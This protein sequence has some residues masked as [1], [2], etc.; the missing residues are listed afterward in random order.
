MGMPQHFIITTLRCVKCRHKWVPRSNRLPNV[1]PGCKSPGWNEHGFSA[2]FIKNF[3][4]HVIK[5]GEPDACWTCP[6]DLTLCHAGA[7]YRPAIISWMIESGEIPGGL[8]VTNRCEAAN[9]VRPSHLSLIS[10][11]D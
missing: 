8:V 4:S 7:T 5:G 10:Q 11:K 3:W 6:N 1:C 9:C 2:A